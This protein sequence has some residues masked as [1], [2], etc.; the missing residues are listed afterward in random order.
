MNTT[1]SQDTYLQL[2]TC[3]QTTK[4]FHH[5][6]VKFLQMNSFC[7]WMLCRNLTGIGAKLRPVR[8]R[9]AGGGAFRVG[10]L[11]TR[12]SLLSICYLDKLS[13]G[14]CASQG[15]R[16]YASL[17]SRGKGKVG[18]SRLIGWDRCARPPRGTHPIGY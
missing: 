7:A 15:Y 17:D 4:K 14:C 3:L 8:V 10:S 9:F 11:C 5:F 18:T 6:L 2:Y 1:K 12:G 16:V 13:T